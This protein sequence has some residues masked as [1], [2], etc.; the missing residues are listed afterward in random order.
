MENFDPNKIRIREVDVAEDGSPIENIDASHIERN[1][2]TDARIRETM[3]ERVETNEDW[4]EYKGR[5]K[6]RRVKKYAP[7]FFLAC[8]FSGIAFTATVESP[9]GVLLGLAFGFLSFVDPIYEK[10]MEKITK[11]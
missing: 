11:W 4:Y 10:I 2:R 3:R 7:F 6:P 1:V 8:L 9:A 5:R